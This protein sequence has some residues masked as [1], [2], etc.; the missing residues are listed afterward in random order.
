M[1]LV[2]YRLLRIVRGWNLIFSVVT[3]PKKFISLEAREE[4]GL[5]NIWVLFL[6]HEIGSGCIRHG[7]NLCD[8]Q[9]LSELKN[10]IIK[11]TIKTNRLD[12][13]PF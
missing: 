3:I 12:D 2:K 5:G 8:W 7:S 9:S 4:S 11:I 6:T 13:A 10:S 1:A